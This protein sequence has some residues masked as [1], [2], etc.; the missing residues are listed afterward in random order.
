MVKNHFFKLDGDALKDKNMQTELEKVILPVKKLA[1]KM[2]TF[3]QELHH[4]RE[5]SPLKRSYQ[6][7]HD[8]SIETFEAA[9]NKIQDTYLLMQTDI[10]KSKTFCLSEKKLGDFFKK[11]HQFH[12][13][14]LVVSEKTKKLTSSM[15]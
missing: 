6:S 15:Q 2:V 5:L 10:H 8:A 14:L 11:T 9:L 7:V 13:A 1:G 3:I 4:P 12:E